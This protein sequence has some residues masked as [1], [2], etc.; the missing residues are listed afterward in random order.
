V[1]VVKDNTERTTYKDL[2]Y[3]ADE[4][5]FNNYLSYFELDGV[6]PT[7]DANTTNKATGDIGYIVNDTEHRILTREMRE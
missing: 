5:N 7:Y 1:F 4:N 6:N 2:F 3:V